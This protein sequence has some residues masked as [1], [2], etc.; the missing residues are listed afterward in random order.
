[1]CIVKVPHDFLLNMIEF[2]WYGILWIHVFFK[3]GFLYS[4]ITFLCGYFCLQMFPHSCENLQE[5]FGYASL[6]SLDLK[7]KDNAVWVTCEILR[8]QTIWI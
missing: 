3:Y 8:E 7:R 2:L 5:Y 6:W 1:M 4:I